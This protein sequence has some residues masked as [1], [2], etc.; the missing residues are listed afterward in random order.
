MTR[1]LMGSENRADQA[2]DFLSNWFMSGFLVG[3]N[4]RQVEGQCAVLER[5]QAAFWRCHAAVNG[6][7]VGREALL[8]KAQAPWLG[9]TG[10]GNFI[11]ALLL[12]KK[13]PNESRNRCIF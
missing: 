10:L 12:L 4:W 1:S 9:N 8:S 11:C 5:R 6:V 2:W 13:Y 7:K 3:A